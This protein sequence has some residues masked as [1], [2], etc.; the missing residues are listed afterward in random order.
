MVTL[1]LP[2]NRF[3]PVSNLFPASSGMSIGPRHGSKS[4]R[5]LDYTQNFRGQYTSFAFLPANTLRRKLGRINRLRYSC[6]SSADMTNIHPMRASVHHM[7]QKIWNDHS[8]DPCHGA[9]VC[10]CLMLLVNC[11]YTVPGI[12]PQTTFS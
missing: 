11:L 12:A 9:R 6:L 4:F 1:R 8:G 7:M 10:I 5:V 3:H 2:Q